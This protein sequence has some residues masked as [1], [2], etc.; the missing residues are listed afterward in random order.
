MK[1]LSLALSFSDSLSSD[2]TD[3]LSEYAELGIDAIMEEGVL[4]ELPIV[5][6]VI[7]LYRIG[8]SIRDRNNIKKL[9]VFIQQIR[10]GCADAEK[11]HKYREDFTTKERFR[12]QQLEYILIL[13]DRYISCDKPR[14]LAKLYLAYLDET[15]VWEEFVMYAEV[16]DRF[17]LLDCSM[18]LSEATTFHTTR[19][20]G[21]ESIL[22]LV[23]L[24]LMAE[25][26][27]ISLTEA[28]RMKDGDTRSITKM[29]SDSQKKVYR[30]TEF[31]RI[32]AN[33]LR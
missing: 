10:R 9:A 3:G 23:G 18:L 6:T 28:R 33:I 20:I 25:D 15:I 32:L 24:G 2:I 30:R 17:L 16:I 22:R 5:H 13:L 8:T 27:S 4:K 19:N 11:R 21:A 12:S 26:N 31:G 29:R 14:M 1:D 7:A